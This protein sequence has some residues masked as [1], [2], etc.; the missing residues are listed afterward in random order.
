MGKVIHGHCKGGKS[1]TTYKCWNQSKD[2]VSCKNDKNYE[3]YSKLG[4]YKPWF[5][6]FVEF[7]KDVGE[8]PPDKNTLGRIDN[9]IG[10][11]PGNVRWENR[12]EQACN[13]STNRWITCPRTNTTRCLQQWAD[14]LGISRHAISKRLKLGW[15]DEDAL[16]KP[17]KPRN[18][19]L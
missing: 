16:Y 3:H 15:S 14:L 8:C 1:T 10:Y 12:K 5:D 9:S 11:F 17:I 7:L 13:R 6:S 18:N 19:S 2:R 4:M